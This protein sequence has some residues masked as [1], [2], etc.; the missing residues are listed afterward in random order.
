MKNLSIALLVAVPL[1]TV[2]LVTGCEV[3]GSYTDDHMAVQLG[4]TN[5]TVQGQTQ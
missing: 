5:S 2:L 4:N 1:L 3:S